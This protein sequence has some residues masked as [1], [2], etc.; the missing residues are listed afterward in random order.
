MRSYFDV[1]RQTYPTRVGPV[2]LPILYYNAAAVFASFLV[3]ID[4]AQ[5]VLPPELKAV[6]LRPGKGLVTVAFFEYV[7]TSVGPYNEMGV[8]VAAHPV[9]TKFRDTA[10]WHW[11]Q[12]ALPGMYVA[13]LPVT[14]A[15]AH[16]A[17]HDCWGYPK[18]IV[19]IDF[20]LRDRD[21]ECTVRSEDGKDLLCRLSGRVGWGVKMS[22]PNLMTY[23]LFKGQLLRTVINTRGR[24]RHGLGGDV[25]LHCD[26]GGNHPLSARL[27]DLGLH[28]A[29][30]LMVQTIQGMHAILPSGMPVR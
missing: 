19:P 21:L 23:T 11:G 29:T 25:S 22:A 28:G 13:D 15:A 5:A 17:G 9:K 10:A 6:P 1:D 4:K 30:P 16:A 2:A 27:R 3:D 14:T 20:Q 12:S 8:A 18:I 7:D 24:M 26:G